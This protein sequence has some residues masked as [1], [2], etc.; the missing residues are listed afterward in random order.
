MITVVNK[1]KHEPT[2]NDVYVGRGSVVGNPFT[3]NTGKTKAE[4]IVDT[5]EK[6]IA[7]YEKWLLNK[8][9]QKDKLVCDELNRL[10]SLAKK[11]NVNLVCYC[12]PQ[13]CHGDVIKKVIE[14]K[15]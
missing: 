11:G 9:E 3:H 14:S 13:S 6:A 5:R 8:I 4:F 7:E 12:S 15:L 1:Y 2:V 10:Y